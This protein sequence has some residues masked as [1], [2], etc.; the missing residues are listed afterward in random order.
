MKKSLFAVL[1]LAI[2]LIATPVMACDNCQGDEATA[3]GHYELGLYSHDYDSDYSMSDGARAGSEGNVLGTVDTYANSEDTYVRFFW[4]NIKVPA[5]AYETGGLEGWTDAD[6]FANTRDYG[7]T[8]ESCAFSSFEGNIAGAGLAEGIAGNRETVSGDLSFSGA[9]W[10]D[11]WAGELGYANGSGVSAGS[12]S[13]AVATAREGFYD[14]GRGL[15][16][17][18]DS[19][20]GNVFTRGNSFVTIDAYG[21]NRSLAAETFT[22]TGF[23]TTGCGS[24]SMFGNGSVSGLIQNAGSYAGGNAS[25]SYTGTGMS[26]RGGAVLDAQINTYGGYSSGSVSGSSYSTIGD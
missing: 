8:S 7:N 25:F 5:F 15:A 13:E 18:C 14:S 9:V 4:W 10:Q 1:F 12:Y 22:R 6:A 24:A 3:T 17:D 2:A 23:E 11:N 16:V 20:Y 21:S 26:A 19:L